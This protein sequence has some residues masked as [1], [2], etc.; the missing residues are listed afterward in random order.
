MRSQPEGDAMETTGAMVSVRHLNVE[1][2]SK[3]AGR[4]HNVRAV[5]DVSFDVVR[6]STYGIVGESGSGKST[7]VR[8]ILGLAESTGEIEVDGKSV[9]DHR[10]RLRSQVRSQAQMVF[11]DPFTSLNPRR[12]V[13]D[14]LAESK[15]V[16]GA[17][18]SSKISGEIN[19]VTKKVGL[20]D[21]S[22]QKLPGGFSG[23]QRQ[24][25]GIARALLANP[26]ILLLDEPTSALDVSV[27]AQVL[28]LLKE[29]QRNLGLTYIFISHDLPVVQ[30][31]C[32]RI[33]VMKNG[34]IVEVGESPS[35]FE[36]PNHPFTKQLV[37]SLDVA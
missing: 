12:R 25:I 32:D 3:S 35:L 2:A 22:L 29:L 8:A 13:Y 17:R 19:E 9:F 11:Q 26:Q 14:I 23:G 1:F 10:G 6:G 16:T 31:M 37:S 18:S 27:Q 7:T 30:Y 34:S 20:A 36:N 5:K 24:R 21:E 15:R 4:R 33:A 28:N